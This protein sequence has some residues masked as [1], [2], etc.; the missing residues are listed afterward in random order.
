MA[1]KCINTAFN[2]NLSI[3]REPNNYTT[4]D[5]AEGIYNSTYT[6]LF[7]DLDD[8]NVEAFSLT[9]QNILGINHSS[10]VTPSPT[11]TSFT[12]ISVTNSSSTSVIPTL[13]LSG[14]R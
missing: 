13:T 7:Y 1:Y 8:L 10:S 14:T 9:G 5:T 2:G 3:Y 12:I 4:E 11:I 6:I